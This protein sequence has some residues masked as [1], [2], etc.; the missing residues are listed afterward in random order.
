MAGVRL[1]GVKWNGLD[2]FKDEL[3]VMAADLV[4]EA[5]AILVESAEAA[6]AAIAAAYPVRKGGLRRGLVLQPSRGT[7]LTGVELR[8]TAPHGHLYERGTV[9]R[10]NKAGAHRGFVKPTPTFVPIAAAYRRT[11]ITQITYRLYAHGA[12]RVSGDADEE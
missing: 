1:A 6:K 4:D 8:Q 10:E 12:T 7:V 2:T 9:V 11:A 5:N 3:H